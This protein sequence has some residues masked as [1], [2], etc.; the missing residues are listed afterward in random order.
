MSCEIIQPF[1][2]PVLLQEIINNLQNDFNGKS[3]LDIIYPIASTEEKNK[4]KLPFIYLND[5]GKDYIN[6]SPDENKKGFCFFELNGSYIINREEDTLEVKL[7]Q[8]FWFNLNKIDYK[9]Y[10]YTQELIS[11]I[12]KTYNDGYYKND[13]LNIEIKEN[14]VFD[15]YDIEHEKVN[16]YPY[17]SVKIMIDLLIS[18]N[19]ECL[20]NF[21]IT[22]TSNDC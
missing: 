7:N 2:N 13:L 8:I 16:I 11:D 10:D 19:T 5:G 4:L 3:Y 6:P 15:N 17:S 14:N 12:I 18:I 22:G 21:T 9:G 20:S 1:S